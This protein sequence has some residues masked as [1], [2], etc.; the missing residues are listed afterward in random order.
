MTDHIIIISHTHMQNARSYPYAIRANNNVKFASVLFLTS[1]FYERFV[2]MYVA[3]SV[4][5]M[6]ERME[7]TEVSPVITGRYVER[8]GYF[9]AY[10]HHTPR[11]LCDG[12]ENTVCWVVFSHSCRVT[13]CDRPSTSAH[14]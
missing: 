13:S 8:G 7:Q 9:S 10:P 3:G 4:E 14:G 11:L 6:R 12:I 1:N 5:L 2:L